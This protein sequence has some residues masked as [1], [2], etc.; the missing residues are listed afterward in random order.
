MLKYI[1]EFNNI[2]VFKEYRYLFIPYFVVECNK[3]YTYYNSFKYSLEDL[4]EKYDNDRSA[5]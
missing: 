4:R 3:K 2:R 5:D 1:T